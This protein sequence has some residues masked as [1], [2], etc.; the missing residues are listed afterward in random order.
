M[1][2]YETALGPGRAHDPAGRGPDGADDRIPD[3]E[4]GKE[5]KLSP[6]M[7]GVL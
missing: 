1:K 2:A 6:L 5:K 7:E 4:T 3:E